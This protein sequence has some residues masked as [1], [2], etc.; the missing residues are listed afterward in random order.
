MMFA[1]TYEG[2]LLGVNSKDQPG[3][4]G[5]KQAMY[6]QLGKPGF[7]EIAKKLRAVAS[8]PNYLITV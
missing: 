5:Y 2:D 6:G 1:V 7:E 8:D 3:V 4:E